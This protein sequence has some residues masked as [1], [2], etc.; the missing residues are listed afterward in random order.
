MWTH[1]LARVDSSPAAGLPTPRTVNTPIY[2]ALLAAAVPVLKARLPANVVRPG[3]APRRLSALPRLEAAL[4][5]RR[6]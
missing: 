3:A 5:R 2:L 1:A 6:A 4:A